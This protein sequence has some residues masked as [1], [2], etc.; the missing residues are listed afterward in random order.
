MTTPLTPGSA[1]AAIKPSADPGIDTENHY[2][3]GEPHQHSRPAPPRLG[4]VIRETE[5]RA[6]LAGDTS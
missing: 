5:V 6:L 3:T 2:E 4:E 1:A